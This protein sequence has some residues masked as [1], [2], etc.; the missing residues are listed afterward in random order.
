[1]G[2]RNK[3]FKKLFFL[4]AK[5]GILIG[6]YLRK[7]EMFMVDVKKLKLLYEAVIDGEELSGNNLVRMG[8]NQ[9]DVLDLLKEGVLEQKNRQLL[10]VDSDSLYRYR[11]ELISLG[12]NERAS[13]CYRRCQDVNFYHNY[14]LVYEKIINKDFNVAFG[15]AEAGILP[16]NR[17]DGILI[18]YMINYYAELPEVKQKTALKLASELKK[19]DESV[20]VQAIIGNRFS[21][22]RELFGGMEYESPNKDKLM[23]HIFGMCSRRNEEFKMR[24]Y[25][26]ACNGKFEA[27]YTLLEKEQKARGL[28]NNYMHIFMVLDDLL[29]EDVPEVSDEEARNPLDAIEVCNYPLAI[30]LLPEMKNNNA[31][32]E[33]AVVLEILLNKVLDRVNKAA[34][35]GNEEEETED[36]G[37]LPNV[38]EVTSAIVNEGM[39]INEAGVKFSLSL[40][41]LCLVKLVFAKG[42]YRLCYDDVANKLVNEVKRA[43]VKSACVLKAMDE[44]SV[45]KSCGLNLRDPFACSLKRVNVVNLLKK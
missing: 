20:F 22:A 31:I 39:S 25:Q 35:L 12:L 45:A 11:L 8:F 15:M 19:E 4:W 36:L 37:V 13:L 33:L 17:V 9:V 24:V 14:L 26:L 30:K 29:S 2:D 21:F 44:A 41:Q 32:R 1:M 10:F 27:L 38:S 6:T 5:C 7:R 23:K 40:E 16:K 42:F 28:N 3:G 43:N 18:M 34:A